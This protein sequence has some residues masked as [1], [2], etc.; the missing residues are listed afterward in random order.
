MCTGAGG[1]FFGELADEFD[2]RDDE[3]Y[4]FL[5]GVTEDNLAEDGGD[6]V[7]KVDYGG[8]GSG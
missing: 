1:T 2:R 7:V 5:L 8:F 3:V 6:G 4:G